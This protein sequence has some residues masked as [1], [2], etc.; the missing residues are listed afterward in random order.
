MKRISWIFTTLAAL[1]FTGLAQAQVPSLINYQGRLTD[2]AGTPVNGPVN[3]GTKIFDAATDG[4]AYYTEE[5][6][7]VTVVNGVY[8]FNYGAGKSVAEATEI[9]ATG[10]GTEKVFTEVVSSP[11]I[12][13]KVSITDGTSIWTSDGS[14]TQTEI[15]GTVDAASGTVTAIFLKTAPDEG[16]DILVTYEHDKEGIFAAFASTTT[17]WLELSINGKSLS[18]RQRLIAVPYAINAMS[19]QDTAVVS[20]SLNKLIAEHENEVKDIYRNLALLNSNLNRLASENT[21]I[22]G[23]NSNFFEVFSVGGGFFGTVGSTTDAWFNE[24]KYVGLR[25]DDS[26]NRLTSWRTDAVVGT[27]GKLIRYITTPRYNGTSNLSYKYTDGE[28]KNCHLDGAYAIN[29]EPTKGVEHVI[30]GGQK[31]VWNMHIFY[32]EQVQIVCLIPDNTSF[33]EQIMA[34]PVFSNFPE[35]SKAEVDVVYQSGIVHFEEFGEWKQNPYKSG[36]PQKVVI[37]LTP[38]SE[39]NYDGVPEIVSINIMS[40][41]N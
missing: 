41:S 10:D 24:N 38:N 8:S 37:Y 32:N 30:K 34:S 27:G 3:I 22:Q 29:P 25:L 33:G 14:S 35:G 1:A 6:G 17:P 2:K 21:I 36:S 19:S 7:E 26:N 11:P 12:V 15:L 39:A 31:N 16:K 23:S 40:K 18:P 13:G 4:K 5:I 9:L 20:E 28:T